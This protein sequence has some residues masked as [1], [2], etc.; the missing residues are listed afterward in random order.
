LLEGIVALIIGILLLIAAGAIRSFPALLI[1]MFWLIGGILSIVSISVDRSQRGWKLSV[2][3]LGIVAGLF[4]A[5]YALGVFYFPTTITM[6]SIGI[7]GI[8]IGVFK[9]TQAFQG[10]GWGV[11]I[12]GV[13]SILFG[14]GLVAN[15]LIS[16]LVLP[17]V[18]RIY[19]IGSIGSGIAVIVLALLTKAEPAV[20][21]RPSPAVSPRPS[22]V[23]P[24][25]LVRAEAVALL[26]LGI[27]WIV[28]LIVGWTPRSLVVLPLGIYWLVV[29]I[30]RIVSILIDKSMWGW[31]LLV[32]ILAIIA[33]IL[34]ALVPFSYWLSA[35]IIIILGTVGLVQAFRGAARGTGSL[36][37]V[38]ILI[39]VILLVNQL[40]F[41]VLLSFSGP[42]VLGLLAIVGGSVSIVTT[43]RTRNSE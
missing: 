28:L 15:P 2:G 4:A 8:V 23:V 3:I 37:L 34:F 41:G 1:G 42:L 33:G 38:Y 14:I 36:G 30:L 40:L 17:L 5:L 9:L 12:L 25:W 7:L 35:P 32:G 10:G 21:P 16:P 13:L 31:K 6:L 27:L 29:G 11:G 26:I 19:S 22:H 18:L 43:M 39:G 20:S 24:I